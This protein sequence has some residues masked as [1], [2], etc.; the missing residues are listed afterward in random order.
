MSKI[1]YKYPLSVTDRQILHLPVGAEILT[2]QTQNEKP[3]LWAM[4]DPKRGTAT[5]IIE[6]FGTGYDITEDMGVERKYI[7]TYQLHGG[8]LIFHVFEYTGI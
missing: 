7:S 5:R 6:T 8:G 1:I 4:V 3:C 2:V